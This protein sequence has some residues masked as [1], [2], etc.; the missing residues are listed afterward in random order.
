MK[1]SIGKM[2]NSQ[3]IPRAGR[4]PPVSVFSGR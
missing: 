2:G 4:I 3:G 1:V